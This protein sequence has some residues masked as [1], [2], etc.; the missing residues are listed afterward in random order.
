[1]NILKVFKIV[2]DPVIL[3]IIHNLLHTHSILAVTSATA[4]RKLSSLYLLKI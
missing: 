3:L 4:E 2:C 1:M